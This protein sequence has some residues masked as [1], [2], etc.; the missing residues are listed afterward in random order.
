MVNKSAGR[1]WAA[2]IVFLGLSVAAIQLALWQLGRAD[3]KQAMI[4]QRSERRAPI[5]IGSKESTLR[6]SPDLNPQVLDQQAVVLQG[7]WLND[8]SIALDNRA[9]EG[10]AGVHILTPM[11]L[12]DGSHVWINRGWMAKAPGLTQVQIAPAEDAKAI[13][14]IALASVMK[15]ME[16]A[17]QDP[18][19]QGGNVWQNFDWELSRQRVNGRVWPVIVWQTSPAGDGLLKKVPE[20]TS[21]VPKHLGYALQWALLSVLCLYFAWRMRPKKSNS[22]QH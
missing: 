10:R 8:A 7:Q 18:R 3:E 14:G 15:R 20:V 5:E 6:W 11:R 4:D 19:T 12:A 16:L 1:S 22:F 2:V 9:W 21:D 13:E 17:K